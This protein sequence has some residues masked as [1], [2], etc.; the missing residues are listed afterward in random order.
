MIEM[1]GIIG[2]IIGFMLTKIFDFSSFFPA[3]FN[4]Y[5]E[6]ALMLVGVFVGYVA[7]KIFNWKADVL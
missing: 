5:W 3:D 2:A 4:D 1:G 6:L 7:E